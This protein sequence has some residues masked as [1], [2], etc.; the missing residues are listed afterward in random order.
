MSMQ[1]NYRIVLVGVGGQGILFMTRIIAETAIRLGMEVI[2]SET[3]GMSQRGGSVVSHLK[4]NGNSPLV[5]RGTADI[6]IALD[7][8]EVYQT[9]DFPKEGGICFVNTAEAPPSF[10]QD[11][12]DG[13]GLTYCRIDADAIA[14]ELGSPRVAN[15]ALLGFISSHNDFRFTYEQVAYTIKMISREGLQTINA[16]ALKRGADFAGSKVE[17]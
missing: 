12:I 16:E 5:R 17:I 11:Y 14:R 8:N 10:L 4:I 6:L 15:T 13:R 2:G 9:L 7:K 1:T 3:H